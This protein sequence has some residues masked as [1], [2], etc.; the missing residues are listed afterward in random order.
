MRA[1]CV[2][3]SLFCISAIVSKFVA[4]FA[5]L[6]L[7]AG[8]VAVTYPPALSLAM[9]SSSCSSVRSVMVVFCSISSLSPYSRGLAL[10]ACQR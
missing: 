10:D 4:F 9:R 1:V 7:R 8:L 3:L 2:K 6:L 5:A